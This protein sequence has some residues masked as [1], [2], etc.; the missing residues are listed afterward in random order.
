M[1][2]RQRTNTDVYG[3]DED[4]QSYILIPATFSLYATTS[5]A[6]SSSHTGLHI[7]LTYTFMIVNIHDV[8]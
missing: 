5:L 4:A 6:C 1:R 2:N 3:V 7:K 8:L